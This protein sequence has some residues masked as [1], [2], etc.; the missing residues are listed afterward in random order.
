MPSELRL[1]FRGPTPPL[2]GMKECYVYLG[3]YSGSPAVDEGNH[4]IKLTSGC[5]T[6]K[7]L[8][9]EIEMLIKSLRE[10]QKQARAKFAEFSEQ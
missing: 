7:E 5:C 1:S 4:R 8:D 6:V 9:E 2:F 10:V 3:S